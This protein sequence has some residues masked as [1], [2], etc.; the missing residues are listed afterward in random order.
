MVGGAR[1]GLPTSGVS[2]SSFLFHDKQLEEFTRMSENNFDIQSPPCV[3]CGWTDNCPEKYGE[4]RTYVEYNLTLHNYCLLM[5]SGIWQRG[6]ENE[7][8][9][10]FLIED[11]RKEVNRAARL[12]R[13]ICSLQG[14]K[15]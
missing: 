4:K 15:E 14:K 10:G 13:M 1:G 12:V 8:V 6:E 3:L 2:N 5:S 7:G 11:I 9:D